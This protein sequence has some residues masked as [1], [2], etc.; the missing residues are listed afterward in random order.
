[1][2]HPLYG[3]VCSEGG[4]LVKYLAI[5]FG[6]IICIGFISIVNQ[7]LQL[8]I[9]LTGIVGLSLIG[10]S[11]LLLA[12]SINADRFRTNHSDDMKLEHKGRKIWINRFILVGLPNIVV[13]AIVYLIFFS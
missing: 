13:S 8:F 10:L 1:M 11:V 2:K 3:F 6:L 7:N 5:G 9:Q 4:I 12:T